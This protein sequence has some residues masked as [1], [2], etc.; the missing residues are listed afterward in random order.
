VRAGALPKVSASAGAGSGSKATALAVEGL[1]DIVS[2]TLSDAALAHVLPEPA[3]LEGSR[4]SESG[5][6]REGPP[7]CDALAALRA[8]QGMAKPP[9]A[10]GA[11][12]A[13]PPASLPSAFKSRSMAPG[14]TSSLFGVAPGSA[15]PAGV[16]G[17]AGAARG[18][19][20]SGADDKVLRVERDA[21]WL[22]G[23]GMRVTGLLRKALPPLCTHPRP[24]VREAVAN[25]E[26]VC[27]CAC[28]HLCG[29]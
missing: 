27:T 20:S 15:Q 6:Q 2:L 29:W 23:S 7:A 12:G 13:A 3:T 21:A 16:G 11:P 4:G 18:L 24:A 28:L 1:A 5:E 8:L 22:A 25:G 17:L 10:T 9:V 19:G 14:Q 26:S